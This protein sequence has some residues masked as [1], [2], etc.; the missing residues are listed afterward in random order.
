MAKRA[1]RPSDGLGISGK[2]DNVVAALVVTFM[3]VLVGGLVGSILVGW[4]KESSDPYLATCGTYFYFIG[5]WI[6]TVALMFALRGDRPLLRTMLGSAAPGNRWGNTAR[7]CGLGIAFGFIA[8]ALCIGIAYAAGGFQLTFDAFHIVPLLVIFACVFVQSGA[9]ELICRGF[10][11]QHVKRRYRCPWVAIGVSGLLF[12]VLHLMN[13]GITVLSFC[14]VTFVGIFFALVVYCTESLWFAML[15]HTAWNFTQNILFGLPNSGIPAAYSVFK[16]NGGM[17]TA[18]L[19]YD[20]VFG[21]EGTVTAVVIFVAMSAVVVYLFRDKLLKP[22]AWKVDAPA[23]SEQAA[24][25]DAPAAS[26]QAAAPDAPVVSDSSGKKRILLHACCGPCSLEPTR[27]LCEQGFE[28]TIYYANSNIEPAAEYARR[29]ETLQQWAADE[30]LSVVE[31]PYDNAAWRAAVAEQHF[32]TRAERCRACYRHRFE[33]SAQYAAV[34]G[35]EVLGT[36]LSVSPYQHT[37]IIREELERAAAAAGIEA[38]FQDYRP[39]YD[40]ATRRSRALGMYRQNYC[41]CALSDAEAQRERE[42]RKAARKAQRAAEQEAYERE[43]AAEL[44]ASREAAE[45][46]RAAKQAYADK[47][48]RKKQLLRELRAK[49][50]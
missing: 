32:E 39:Q 41:G 37:H 4:L 44:T 26:E 25:P 8:N 6:V 38:R 46:A 47:Q 42:E 34:Q 19:F 1:K 10:L 30:G 40:E 36:T 20:P 17:G 18:S 22:S 9:E 5:C 24:A 7:M 13:T 21:V 48:A 31:G 28:P 50:E 29:L 23:V 14:T 43:H 3:L 11:L 35:Y 27:I 2:L 15:A 33:E 49:G 45:Q 12:S 16:L